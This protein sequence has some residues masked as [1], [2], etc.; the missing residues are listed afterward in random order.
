MKFNFPEALKIMFV[1]SEKVEQKY[2]D[3]FVW[4][5]SNVCESPSA[6]G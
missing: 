4:A 5:N 6:G 3:G 2:F 1:S